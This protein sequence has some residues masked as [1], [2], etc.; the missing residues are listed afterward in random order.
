M[1]RLIFVL[2]ALFLVCGCAS[3]QKP[4]PN[5]QKKAPDPNAPY[6]LYVDP[7]VRVADALANNREDTSFTQTLARDLHESVYKRILAIPDRT[8]L[9]SDRLEDVNF[10][11][12]T[13]KIVYQIS[14]TLTNYEEGNG[15]LRYLFG[16]WPTWYSDD[17]AIC[18]YLAGYVTLQADCTVMDLGKK[19]Q[20]VQFSAKQKYSGN[21][22]GGL[23]FF[24]FS[25]DYVA[26][27]TTRLLADEII[28]KLAD[29]L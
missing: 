17:Y 9:V 18:D 2:L 13:G 1:R 23:N 7:A 24:V 25:S 20:V 12:K 28:A 22:H 6:L 16:D 29:H 3:F 4:A 27:K 15:L 21:P 26:G 11:L 19:T 8:F 5:P 10:Y 14:C